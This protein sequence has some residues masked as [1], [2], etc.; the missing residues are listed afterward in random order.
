MTSSGIGIGDAVRFG[1]GAVRRLPWLCRLAITVLA[2]LALG[3]CAAS[4]SS[5]ADAATVRP[6]VT[7]ASELPDHPANATVVTVIDGDTLV[8]EIDGREEHVRLLGIDTP[9]T[10]DPDGPVECFG[11]EASARLADLVPEG[12]PVQLV[13]DV[14]PRDRYD[15]LLAHVFRS[16][17]GLFVNLS[18]VTDGYADILV[19]EPNGAYSTTFAAAVEAARS[20]G[21]GLWGACGTADLPIDSAPPPERGG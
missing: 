9:E 18:L 17:D 19:I 5:E 1:D 20:S 3:A 16:A 14:E 11:A 2:G 15:R 21:L 6:N 13:L 8:A 10:V 7:A 12:T 4:S